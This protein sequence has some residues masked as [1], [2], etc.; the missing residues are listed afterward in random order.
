MQYSRTRNSQNNYPSKKRPR[1]CFTAGCGCLPFY[2]LAALLGLFAGIYFFFPGQT[3]LL[4]L[5]IDGTPKNS[6]AGRSDTNIMLNFRTSKPEI[7]FLSLPRDLWLTIP[8]YGENRINT[9][10]FFAE[11]N[12]PGEGP[13][14]ALETIQKNFAIDVSYFARVRFDGVREIVD[15]LG[16]VEIDLVKPMAGYEAGKHALN[17][18]KALAFARNRSGSDDFSRME[19]GQILIKAILRK[20]ISPLNWYRLPS[21]FLAIVNSIDTNLPFWLWPRLAVVTL[22]VGP[23]GINSYSI[24]RDMVTPMTTDQGAAVLLPNWPVIYSLISV[25]F[26]E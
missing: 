25:I 2:F 15:A 24:N 9:A 10:H 11:A 18:R 3:N 16:G 4:M 5:G 17:G 8:G 1:S 6:W 7:N 20:A 14:L 19:Q 21:V 26:D 22:R 23:D 12:S 13:G